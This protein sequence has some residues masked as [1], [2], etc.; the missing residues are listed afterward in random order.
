[1]TKKAMRAKYERCV[2]KVESADNPWAV[3][4]AQM[5]RTYGRAAF[6]AAI[7][8]RNGAPRASIVELS[9]RDYERLNTD[10]QAFRELMDA[11]RDRV[12]ASRRPVVVR[13]AGFEMVAH[14]NGRMETRLA[15]RGNPSKFERLRRRIVAD[16]R[17]RSYPLKD[18]SGRALAAAIGRA[19]YGPKRFA[20]MARHN[21][22]G[23]GGYDPL[24]V[25][26]LW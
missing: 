21:P 23:A 13:M 26:G 5:Q 4:R 16:A 11:V 20:V 9:D 15:P 12:R 17:R 3:C 14:P 2:R 19:K 8:R 18:P 10:A 22:R 25:L 1:M 7:A 24:R 6:E